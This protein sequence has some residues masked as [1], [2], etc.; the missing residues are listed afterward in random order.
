MPDDLYTIAQRQREI[1]LAQDERGLAAVA[2]L[3]TS[4]NEQV[5]RELQTLL[6]RIE[7]ARLA[8]EAVKPSWLRQQNRLS[9]LLQQ[10]Q[11]RLQQAGTLIVPTIS[12]QQRTMGRLGEAS[13]FEHVSATLPDGVAVSF[14]RLPAGAIEAFAGF[15]SDGSPLAELFTDVAKNTA[16]EVGRTLLGG[17][18]SGRSVD[19]L[20]R[21]LRSVA[22]LSR[23]RALTI[24]RT[25]S[26]RAYREAGHQTALQ[27]SQVLIGW[28]WQSTRD[29]RTC[30]ACLAM[31]GTFFELSE[32]LS[33]HP[34]CRCV[35][36]YIS[37]AWAQSPQRMAR[38]TETGEDWFSTQSLEVRRQVLG[39]AGAEA[40]DAGRVKLQ[41][42]VGHGRHPRWGEVRFQ[43]SLKDA[44]SQPLSAG[45]G[46][47]VD[48]KQWGAPEPTQ[49]PTVT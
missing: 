20:A 44:L 29:R 47:P 4:V 17:I 37:R 38:L 26:I 2:R 13:L 33:S 23:H 5:W 36:I 28:I 8:G 49:T 9:L 41:S 46:K 15:A 10:I 42:F 7:A 48:L 1:L 6:D 24:A 43:R 25:E 35:P 31:H 16:S 18:A 14:T 19:E 21:D 22:N 40:Y 32:R 39:I 3:Y 45:I 30:A 34:N 12:D 27:N 11:N